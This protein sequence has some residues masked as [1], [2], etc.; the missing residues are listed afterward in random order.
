MND[1]PDVPAS[2]DDP[3]RTGHEPTGGADLVVDERLDGVDEVAG[4]GDGDVGPDDRRPRR[5]VDRGLLVACFVIAAGLALIIWG[6]TSALTGSDGVDRPDVIEEISPVENA[7]Q[8]LQQGNVMVDLEFGYEAV[9]VV[10]GIEL[11]TSRLGEVR[12]DVEPGQQQTTDPST[13]V[14][15]PGNARISFQPTEGAPIEQFTE[16][17]HTAQVIYWKI[18]EGRENAMSYRWSFDVI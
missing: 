15:D 2:T 3:A 12:D 10:D 11:D 13:A 1:T 7:I 17:R 14:F 9:L 5:R 4:D 6:M 18:E 8:V 16:G